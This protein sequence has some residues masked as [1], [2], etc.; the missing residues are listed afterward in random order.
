MFTFAS[1]TET[2]GLV[3]LEA[4]Q[5]GTPVVTTAVMG[6]AE[7]MAD[8]L[9]G[10]VAESDPADFAAKVGRVLDDAVLHA[11]LRAEAID[12]AARWSAPVT[13]ERLLE[14][15]AT[16]KGTEATSVAVHPAAP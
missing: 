8:G 10:L 7:V 6:T 4:M 13:T 12:K 3:L 2:Q 16:L 1:S 15:Y 5:A 9:G 11:R 14:L